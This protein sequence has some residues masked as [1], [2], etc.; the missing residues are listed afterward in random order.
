MESVHEMCSKT[1]L[2]DNFNQVFT[3]VRDNPESGST[4]Y[5]A[6]KLR[7]DGRMKK[8]R[9]TIVVLNWTWLLSTEPGRTEEAKLSPTVN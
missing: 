2:D 8:G 6:H 1:V 4:L 7:S 9:E 3:R 5:Q